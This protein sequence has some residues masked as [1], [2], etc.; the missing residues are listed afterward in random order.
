M[1]VNGETTRLLLIENFTTDHLMLSRGSV[2]MELEFRHTLH[3]D[4]EKLIFEY[5]M[6]NLWFSL[7]SRLR[8]SVG[9]LSWF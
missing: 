5:L 6:K 9:D 4:V 3:A 1:F 7:G 8:I 2:S